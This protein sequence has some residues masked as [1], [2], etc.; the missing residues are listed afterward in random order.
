M[1]LVVVVV[2]VVVVV[3]DAAAAPAAI[4]GLFLCPAVCCRGRNGSE[5]AAELGVI[6]E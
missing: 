4:S 3:G 1:L 2:V 5:L 6:R